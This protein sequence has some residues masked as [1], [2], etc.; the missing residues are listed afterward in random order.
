M[1]PSWRLSRIIHR[2]HGV[3][4]AAMCLSKMLRRNVS[5]ERSDVPW[6]DAEEVSHGSKANCCVTGGNSRA[7][8]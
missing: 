8:H 6:T 7:P 2:D 3:V 4:I 5:G 1:D